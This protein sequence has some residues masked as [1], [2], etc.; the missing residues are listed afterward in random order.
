MRRHGIPTA[1]FAAFRDADAARRYCRELAGPCVVKTDGLVTTPV[2]T[3]QQWD[4]PNGWAPLQWIA[5]EGLNRY[6]HRSLARDIAHR[7]I[8]ENVAYYERT[9]KLVEKYDVTGDVAAG[10]GEYPL[11]DG[12][13][14]TN[15]VLRRLLDE[16]LA[17]RLTFDAREVQALQARQGFQACIPGIGQIRVTEAELAEVRELRQQHLMLGRREHRDDSLDGLGGA[18]L[19]VDGELGSGDGVHADL[20]DDLLADDLDGTRKM[21]SWVCTMKRNSTCEVPSARKRSICST[22]SCGPPTIS[23]S[24]GFPWTPR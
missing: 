23:T 6:G 5:I 1:R 4:A 19:G 16:C 24:N 2:R 11:Q 8:R 18:C 7:W 12:F 14:W 21:D 17:L 9:G 22:K 20:V 13:G 3:G 10:G 15:G